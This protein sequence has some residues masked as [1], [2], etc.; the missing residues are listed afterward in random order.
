M[1]V[2]MPLLLLVILLL[3]WRDRQQVDFKNERFYLMMLFFS[4][5]VWLFPMK[6]LAA[7]HDYTTM[8]YLAGS[9]AFFYVMTE[10][11]PQTKRLFWITSLVF[12]AS[13]TKFVI[14][15]NR[16]NEDINTLAKNLS[17]VRTEMG[18]YPEIGRIFTPQ[19]HRNVLVNRPYSLGF[20]F[21]DYALTDKLPR[22][23]DWVLESEKGKQFKLTRYMP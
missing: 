21:Y 23:N 13:F 17:A 18:K 6:R 22:E 12:L 3:W 10:F 4:G 8:Y 5:P 20:Y 9:I 14:E 7:P 1:K 16:N 19:G 15:K 2:F 11:I